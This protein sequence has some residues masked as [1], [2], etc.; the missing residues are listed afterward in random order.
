MMN[1][2]IAE[3]LTNQQFKR[4]FGVQRATFKEMVKALQPEWRASPQPG[5]KPKLALCAR[6][7]VALEYWR[8]YRTYPRRNPEGATS[9]HQTKPTIGNWRVSASAWSMSIAA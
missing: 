9:R 3:T 8:E 1:T 4:R 5:A 6:I 2:T 7:L